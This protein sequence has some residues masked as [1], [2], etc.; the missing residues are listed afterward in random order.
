MH[1][2]PLRELPDREPLPTVIDPDLLE[3]LHPG[4]DHPDLPDNDVEKI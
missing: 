3:Q 1:T 4:P 2:V